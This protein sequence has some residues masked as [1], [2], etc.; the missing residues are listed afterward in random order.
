MLMRKCCFGFPSLDEQK[1][2]SVSVRNQTLRPEV[3][4]RVRCTSVLQNDTLNYNPAEFG[5]SSV[6]VIRNA[7]V[8]LGLLII[9][10]NGRLL[11][12]SA[13]LEQTLNW[14]ELEK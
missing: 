11:F 14:G 8:S 7:K 4:K 3:F 1:C 5:D 12:H 9:Q 2:M 10:N 6:C 13:S